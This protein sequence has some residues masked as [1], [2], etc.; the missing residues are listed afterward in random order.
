MGVGRVLVADDALLSPSR[1]MASPAPSASPNEDVRRATDFL[2]RL[3]PP[4]RAFDIRLWDGTVI[5]GEGE[6][7]LTAVIHSPGALRRMLRPPVELRLGEAYLRGDF[8]LE[9][10]VGRAGPALE[11]SRGA[12]A[13]PREALALA[14]LWARLPRERETASGGTGYGERAAQ[15]DAAENS[16]DWDREGI[17]YHYDA[18]NDFFA[19][20]LD[21]RMVY[22]CAYFP[23]GTET[24][25]EAQ[26][27]KLEHI[28]RKLRLR[29]GDRLLDIGCGWG[30]LVIHAARHY[31][32]RALGVTLSQQQADL[33][34]QR[35]AEAGVADRVEV[36]LTDYRDVET[37]G[38]DAVASVGMFEHVG[39]ERLPEYF[40]H[41]FRIL[42]PGGRFLNHGIASRPSTRTWLQAAAR[43]VLDPVLIGGTA[44]RKKYV[45][46]SGGL[47]PVSEANLVAQQAGFEVRDV[48]NLREHY[49]RTLHAWTERLE[50][51]ADE[52]IRLGGERMYRLWRIYMGIASWQFSRGEFDLGQSLL[53]KPAG[54]LSDLP[55]SRAD[56]YAPFDA[57]RPGTNGTAS[58]PLARPSTPGM[59]P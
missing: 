15:I 7:A 28:C 39:R 8:D 25:D 53:Q 30:A 31:G 46:P 49:A 14:R 44:F 56:L 13:S 1:L 11:A 23:T 26:E 5:P 3:L 51:H 17:Q 27:R 21:R 36:R 47:V 54:G 10:D 50:S 45:F 29:D 9:G 48:E 40:D 42:R 43:R 38:Y 4:P 34:R 55:L 41:V 19:L 2:T 32:V 6:T 16:R 59:D 52:A 57:G 33:A 24:L 18:G 12:T 22:S 35:I 37:A 58:R 20:F